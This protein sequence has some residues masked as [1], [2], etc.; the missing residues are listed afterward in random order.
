MDKKNIL[1][2]IKKCLALSASANE[3]EAAAAL[4]KAKEL[5]DH[6]N[7][8]DADVLTAEVNETRSKA[9]QGASIP[10]YESDL[11]VVVARAFNCRVIFSHEVN[12]NTYGPQSFCRFI[13]VNIEPELAQFAYDMLSRQLRKERAAYIKTKLR[14]CKKFNKTLRADMFCEGWV[15]SVTE[16]VN[17]FAKY[18]PDSPSRK[19]IKAYVDTKFPKLTSLKDNCRTTGKFND[20]NLQD[21]YNGAMAGKDAKLQHGV[22]R[23]RQQE[24]GNKD[25]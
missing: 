12:W 14:R 4:A 21:Y 8:T 20:R 5:M 19:A 10:D 16:A 13:G 2:K 11:A 1:K 6:H 25:S 23:E 22:G 24:L 7:I 9:K 3:H 18:A 17:K 15:N